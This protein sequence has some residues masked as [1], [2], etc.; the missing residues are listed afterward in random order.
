MF[1]LLTAIVVVVFAVGYLAYDR[2]DPDSSGIPDYLA[3]FILTSYV[4]II[5][6][7]FASLLETIF[8]SA[9]PKGRNSRYRKEYDGIGLL[10]FIATFGIVAAVAGLL[11]VLIKVPDPE[12]TTGKWGIGLA[13]TV[14]A[15]T[16][17]ATLKRFFHPEGDADNVGAGRDVVPR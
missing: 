13:A 6:A 2:A 15:G 17:G 8:Q 4:P 12:D 14:W 11:Y 16:V 5:S 1:F 7:T 9:G 3:S 10:Y